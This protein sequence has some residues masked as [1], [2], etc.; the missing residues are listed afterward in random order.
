M[1]YEYF[2]DVPVTD[3][4][5]LE[6][7][8][9]EYP[10]KDLIVIKQ[11]WEKIVQKIKECG[12]NVTVPESLQPDRLET[13]L[14]EADKKKSNIIKVSPMSTILLYSKIASVLNKK[15]RCSVTNILNIKQL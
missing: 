9:Y 10:E 11:D 2:K 5:I 6:T 14:S 1:Y 15:S 13:L 7:L 4:K 3:F 8:L 12:E